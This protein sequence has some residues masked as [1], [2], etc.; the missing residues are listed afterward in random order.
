[1]RPD[2]RLILAICA[3]LIVNSHLEGFYPMGWQCLAA[4]GLLGNSLFYMLSR[5]GIQSSLMSREQDFLSYMRR[6]I[7]RIYP[8]LILVVGILSGIV[9]AKFLTWNLPEYFSVFVW[10]TSFGYVEWIVL[11]YAAGYVLFVPRSVR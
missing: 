2:T 1:M 10:P 11:F 3:L 5:F 6:R 7:L 8:T 4:D 9:G